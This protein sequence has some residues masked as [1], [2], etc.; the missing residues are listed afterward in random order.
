M[1]EVGPELSR[2]I[3]GSRP[4]DQPGR[5]ASGAAVEGKAVSQTRNAKTP[6]RSGRQAGV[7]VAKVFFA[8][9]T[10]DRAV[11][12]TFNLVADAKW[13]ATA[14]LQVASCLRHTLLAGCRR[15]ISKDGSA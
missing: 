9:G 3:R 7:A 10:L 12:W 13:S 8:L 1:R 2:F 15:R 4:V 5:E 6:A 11:S 14:S